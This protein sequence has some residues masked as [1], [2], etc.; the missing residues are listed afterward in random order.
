MDRK[1]QLIKKF[2]HLGK[3]CGFWKYGY[4]IPRLLYQTFREREFKGKTLLEIGCGRGAYIIWASINGATSVVG[5]EPIAEGSASI[6]NG[7]FKDFDYICRTLNLE[8]IYIIPKTLE[9]YMCENNMFDIVLLK[10]SI[11]HI[12]EDSCIRLQESEEAR[13]VYFEI[14]RKISRLLKNNGRIIIMDAARRNFYCDIG[15]KNPFAKTIEWNKHQEPEY[16][17]K[18]LKKCG[19]QYPKITWNSGKYFRYLGI[20]SIPSLLAYFTNSN[21]RLEMTMSKTD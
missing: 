21:F 19:F 20:Y 10:N 3:E 11:N 6:S 12:D 17:E 2:K 16:W 4:A 5:L 8:N 9:E 13:E 7:V 15:V 14:F 1:A 18:L